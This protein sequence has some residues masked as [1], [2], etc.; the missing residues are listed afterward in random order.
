MVP[1][2]DPVWLEPADSLVAKR[3]LLVLRLVELMKLHR[4]DFSLFTSTCLRKRSQTFTHTE[5]HS[6]VKGQPPGEWWD[7]SD[8]R[9]S[10]R[11][12]QVTEPPVALHFC[13]LQILSAAD[14][15]RPAWPPRPASGSAF[16][17]SR[18]DLPQLEAEEETDQRKNVS[19]FLVLPICA[20]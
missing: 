16:F 5:Q 10:S 4:T 12:A 11:K 18:L 2:I 6:G 9:S 8:C 3:T 13:E 20:G 17:T 1:N 15:G 19:T 7:W 14:E